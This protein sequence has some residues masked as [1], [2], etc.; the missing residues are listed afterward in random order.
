MVHLK[1]AKDGKVYVVPG[2]N[3]RMLY[4]TE[5]FTQKPSAWTNIRS[6]LNL[7]NGKF[8][9]VQDNTVS[10]VVVYRVTATDKKATN[11]KPV[12]VPVSKKHGK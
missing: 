8:V 11:I 10:P 7:F 9:L 6:V 3:G 2:I 1:K 4:D 5:T 12:K